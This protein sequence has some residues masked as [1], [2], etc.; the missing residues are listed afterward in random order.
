MNLGDVKS[1]V[2]KKIKP[3]KKEEE[4]VKKFSHK[5]VDALSELGYEALLVGSL[6]K[7][8][9]LTGD[10]DIDLFVLFPKNVSREELEKKG[11]EIGKKACAILK[12]KP[13]LKYAEHP[14][15]KTT[16]HGFD[17]DIV[18][19]YRIDYGEKIISAVDRSPLHL[20]YVLENMKP[21]LR[22]DVRL[23]K[24]YMK[25]IGVYGS[26]VKRLGFSG[27]VC[28]LL[29]IKYGSFDN[30]LKEISKWTLP[31]IVNMDQKFVR[32]LQGYLFISDPVD[33]KRNAS[34]AVSSENLV[35]LISFTR[36]FLKNPDTA[37]F[38]PKTIPLKAVQIKMLKKRGTYYI[39][40]VSKRPDV[41]NDILFPQLRKAVIRLDT[42]LKHEDFHVLNSVA[43]AD[44]NSIVAFFEISSH[45]PSIKQMIGPPINSQIH[46]KEF[47][48]KYSSPNFGPFVLDDKWVVEITR[49]YR[50]PEDL[51][52][53]FLS[54]S[55]EDLIQHGIPKHVVKPIKAS[56]ILKDKEIFSLIKKNK[57][58][59]DFL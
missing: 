5:L 36:R 19:C 20:R 55:D 27:Y 6:G 33:P 18:P 10:H 25:G 51:F 21:E 28:E 3:S 48:S 59:S 15:T 44:N 39:V 16:V 57:I 32:M 43:Y 26:D 9:W 24:Q 35:K 53:D 30:A 23:L 34:A 38:F 12:S 11:L 49:S 14:Y 2:I 56:K 41:I 46:T 40:L 1:A 47:L 7:H 22:D 4:E 45:L 58:L 52:K 8:T 13:V 29:I 37:T 54:N 17:I 42:L 50:K 31:K